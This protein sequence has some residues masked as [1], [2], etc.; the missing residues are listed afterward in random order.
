M[1]GGMDGWK[2]EGRK[3][4]DSMN[5]LNSVSTFEPSGKT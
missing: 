5:I 4:A 1:D 3:G 2:K